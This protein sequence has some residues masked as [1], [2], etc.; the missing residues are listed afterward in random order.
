MGPNFLALKRQLICGVFI[1]YKQLSRNTFFKI[2]NTNSP[3]PDSHST[4]GSSIKLLGKRL[5][6]PILQYHIW[7][8]IG[9]LTIKE[10][11]L[12]CWIR[13]LDMSTSMPNISDDYSAGSETNAKPHFKW[14]MPLPYTIQCLRIT[15]L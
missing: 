5:A 4:P 6:L 12:K 11:L 9:I 2:G 7:D 1:H 13:V 3:L 14:Y 10:V 8:I 15:R